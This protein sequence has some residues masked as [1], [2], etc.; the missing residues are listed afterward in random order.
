MSSA[1][2]VK[3]IPQALGGLNLDAYCRRAGYEGVTLTKPQI[4]PNAA[5]NNW[6][7]VTGGDT[8]PFSMEQACKSHYDLEAVQA[9]PS[10]PDDAYSWVCYSV[11]EPAS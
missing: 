6:R 10:D 8:H 9:H 4:G 2:S 5:F 3:D 11:G 7:C 1:A